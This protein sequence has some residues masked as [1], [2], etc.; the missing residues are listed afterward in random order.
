M[1]LASVILV[2][3]NRH[4]SRFLVEGGTLGLIFEVKVRDYRVYSPV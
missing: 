1:S 4:A 2:T 3:V